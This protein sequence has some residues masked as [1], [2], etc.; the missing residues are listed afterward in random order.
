MKARGIIV[1]LVNPGLVD[2]RGLLALKPG[3]PVPDEFAPLMPLIRNGTVKLTSPAVSVKA[4]IELVEH[5]TPEQ[6]GVFLNYD[7]KE[8][9]W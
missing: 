8:L 1:A 9:P 3:D 2:T 6:A 7:G 5:I 4:M